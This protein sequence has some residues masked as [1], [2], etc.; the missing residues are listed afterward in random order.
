MGDIECPDCVLKHNVPYYVLVRVWN[1]AGLY[2]VATTHAARPDYTAPTSGIV[3]PSKTTISCFQMCSL[4]YQVSGFMDEE[5][6]LQD[7]SFAIRNI[8]GF[9]TNFTSFG[10]SSQFEVSGSSFAHGKKYVAVVRCT[11]VIG[12]ISE[13]IT[14]S[15]TLVDNSPPT[16]VS[17]IW[18]RCLYFHL[19]KTEARCNCV[20]LF[21]KV[22]LHLIYFNWLSHR[23]WKMLMVFLNLIV[24]TANYFLHIFDDILVLFLCVY[25]MFC[26]KLMQCNVLVIRHP[27]NDVNNAL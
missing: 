9:V 15:P 12:L 8:T 4:V 20:C 26:G 7:C 17:F 1:G 10:L 3:E 6:G 23:K 19:K 2:S 21:G 16:K 13:Q 11:N 22:T 5:S 18:L 25:K 24:K 14:S 27:A